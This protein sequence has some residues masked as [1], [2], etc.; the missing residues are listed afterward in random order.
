MADRLCGGFQDARLFL[1][2]LAYRFGA[3]S[4]GAQTGSRMV[5]V[6][7]CPILGPAG[8]SQ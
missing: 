2:E 5:G 6:V 1:L 4:A 7:F 8:L 3:W